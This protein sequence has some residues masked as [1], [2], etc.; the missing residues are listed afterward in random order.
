MSNGI[1]AIY[2]RVSQQKKDKEKFSIPAQE[3]ILTDLAQKS[4]H[5]IYC[6]Y[7]EN[8]DRRDASGET[9]S[10]RPKMIQLL[11]DAKS[12]KFQYCLVIE[13]ERLSR[14]EDMFDWLTIRK[15]F[16]DNS[17]KIITPTQ[18][19]DLSDEDDTFMFYLFGSLSSREKRRTLRRLRR[20]AEEAA[21]KGVY[22]GTR[23]VKY[24]FSYDKNKRKLVPIPSEVELIKLGFKKVAE[25]SSIWSL[26]SYLTTQGYRNR[27]GKPFTTRH[28]SCVLRSRFYVDGH[29]IWNGI[30]SEKPVVEPFIDPETWQKA[31]EVID[32]NKLKY[33]EAFNNRTDSPFELQGV[34]KCRY[35]NGNMAGATRLSNHRTLT[36][37]RTY[38]CSTYLSRGKAACSGQS[39]DAK[40]VESQAYEILRDVVD[41]K[42]LLELEREEIKNSLAERNPEIRKNIELFNRQLNDNRRKQKKCL[43]AYYAMA[44]SKEQF[45]EENTR[46][47][48]EEKLLE[49]ELQGAE[50][51]MRDTRRFEGNIDKVFALLENFDDIWHNLSSNDKK[52]LYRNIFN[53]IY[54]EDKPRKHYKKID[55]YEL[56]EPFASILNYRKYEKCLKNQTNRSVLQLLPSVAR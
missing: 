38:R 4:G 33:G 16:L 18:E 55:K 12:R 40:M 34:L 56:N 42:D 23:H 28:W 41:D 54:I 9:I 6:I 22:L 51:L 21:R 37:K 43:E 46:L 8:Q 36:K 47:L 27:F 19:L 13:L 11:E 15:T 49:K 50:Q 52:I 48:D 25:G 39:I 45:K 14:S 30:R 1:C 7:N 10:E 20:G 26:A 17:V 31:N 24:G 53:F 32:L 3:R 5:A 44:L 2:I 29:L 35:C